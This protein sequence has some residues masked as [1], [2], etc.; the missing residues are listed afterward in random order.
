MPVPPFEIGLNTSVL[1]LLKRTVAADGTYTPSGSALSLY[2]T[3]ETARVSCRNR[4]VNLS[5]MTMRQENNVVVETGTTMTFTGFVLRSGANAARS[6]AFASD[7]VLVSWTE[8]VCTW[9]FFGV[10]ESYDQDSSKERSTYTLTVRHVAD[11]TAPG[12]ETQVSNPVLG[13]TI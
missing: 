5:P 3:V 6:T 9:A 13:G 8:G 11:L 4:V 2:T 12:A 1:T 10:I 7:Y